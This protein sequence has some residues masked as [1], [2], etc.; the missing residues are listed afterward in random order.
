MI[1]YIEEREKKMRDKEEE[2]LLLFSGGDVRTRTRS[3][4][5]TSH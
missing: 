4:G 2:A 5:L 3:K 1:W